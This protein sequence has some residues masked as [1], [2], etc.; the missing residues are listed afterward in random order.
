MT[1][2]SEDDELHRALEAL[3]NGKETTLIL[4]G[5]ENSLHS[6]HSPYLVF[7]K[8]DGRITI[9]DDVEAEGDITG[10]DFVLTKDEA[11][12][13]AGSLMEY[14][15]KGTTSTVKCVDRFD[16]EGSLRDQILGGQGVMPLPAALACWINGFRYE[17][18]GVLERDVAAV[19]GTVERELLYTVGSLL[20]VPDDDPTVQPLTAALGGVEYLHAVRKWVWA[21]KAWEETPKRDPVLE[22][23]APPIPV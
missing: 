2:R 8:T 20:I 15:R 14:V 10:R 16:V 23:D 7:N 17:Y 22:P 6:R 11:L 4:S 21:R 18:D 19:I 1:V 9:S 13:L 12:Q 3:D 5:P